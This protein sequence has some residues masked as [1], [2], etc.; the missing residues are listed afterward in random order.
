MS[1]ANVEIV[2]QALLASRDGDFSGMKAA[3][4]PAIEWDM[5]GVPEWLEQRVYRGPQVWQFLEGWRQSW[6]GWHFEVEEVRGVG[7]QV[8]VG[9]HER[10][11]GADSRTARR[12]RGLG[13]LAGKRGER[14]RRLRQIQA[15][16]S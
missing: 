7:D 5:S 12:L 14:S 4:D 3:C 6:E 2:R 15:R 13:D 8:L 9:I 11:K 1:Q 10:A 16:I